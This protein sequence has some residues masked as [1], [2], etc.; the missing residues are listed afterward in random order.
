MTRIPKNRFRQSIQTLYLNKYNDPVNATMHNRPLINRFPRRARFFFA[1]A[2]LGW[3]LISQAQTVLTIS[4]EVTKPLALQA[5]DLTAMPH[6]E[7]IANDR[8][9]KEHQYAGIPLVD[10]LKQ[11]GVT[12]GGEL[13]GKNLMKYVVIKAIDGY[14]VLFA[15]PELDPDFTT[16]TIL[17]ADR[18]DGAPLPAGVGPYRVVVPGE[19]KLARW[20]REVKVIEVRFAK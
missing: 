12:L 13:R 15:L 9:G 14:E 7:V 11:A 3:P 4:G 20:V 1:L 10:L 19:K 2:L 18:V 5:T 8:D 6:R 16:R 17:L